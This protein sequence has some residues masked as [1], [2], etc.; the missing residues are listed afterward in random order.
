MGIC[1]DISHMIEIN[2]ASSASK[3]WVQ[4]RQ[5]SIEGTGDNAGRAAVRTANAKSAG[6][7]NRLRKA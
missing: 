6:C 4:V 7:E 3:G 5:H 1:P 2:V